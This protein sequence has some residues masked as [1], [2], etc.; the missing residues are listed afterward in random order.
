MI[1]SETKPLHRALARILRPLARLLLRNGVPFG[2]FSEL[3]KQAYV[4]AA[5][6]DFRDSRRKPTDSKAAV[7]TGLTRKEIKRLREL[8]RDESVQTISRRHI[9]RASRVVSG[10]VRDKDFQDAHGEPAMLSFDGSN[11]FTELVKRY[12]GDMTPRAVMDELLRVGVVEQTDKLILRKK[13]YIPTGDDQEMLHI[14]G[15]DVGDLIST[16]D[17]NLT[18]TTRPVRP[19]M[20]QRT[21]T[22]DN[23][24]PEII[25]KWRAHAAQKSQELLETLDLWLAPYDRDVAQRSGGSV[26]SSGDKAAVRTGVSVFY[27]EDPI[28]T[29]RDGEGES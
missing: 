14:F 25:D 10:W 20:Y 2:E 29:D 19:P 13:A 12:S 24:P 21:L 26:R 18:T 5:F 1:E 28:Q 8:T 7:L 17:H 6:E 4:E 3:V 23:I 9:N 22:Y 16:V 15:E 11:S 27:F